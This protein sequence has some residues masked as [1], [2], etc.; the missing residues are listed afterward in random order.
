MKEG[1]AERM[2][3]LKERELSR[4]LNQDSVLNGVDMDTESQTPGSSDDDPDL[5]KGNLI[6][7]C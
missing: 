1:F 3:R 4:E 5:Q 2:F 7:F 6:T